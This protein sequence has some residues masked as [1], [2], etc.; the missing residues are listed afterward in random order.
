[1]SKNFTAICF[2]ISATISCFLAKFENLKKIEK[3]QQYTVQVIVFLL[4]G[5]FLILVVRPHFLKW[6][7]KKRKKEVEHSKEESSSVTEK[8]VENPKK[9]NDKKARNRKK[10]KKK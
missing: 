1:M 6:L 5:S 7:S 3:T 9:Q 10:K 8:R 4:V 2:A